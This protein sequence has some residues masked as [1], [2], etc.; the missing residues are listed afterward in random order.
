MDVKCACCGERR[1]FPE[2]LK[3]ASFPVACSANGVYQFL[4]GL[5]CVRCC[6]VIKNRAKAF[7]KK[8]ALTRTPL[9][10]CLNNMHPD[11]AL[12]LDCL[13]DLPPLRPVEE[14]LVCRVRTLISIHFLSGGMYSAKGHTMSFL[15]DFLLRDVAINLPRLAIEV[16][17]LLIAS[18]NKNT[19]Q[20][21]YLWVRRA[22]VER[23]LR[24]LLTQPHYAG[25]LIDQ[26]ALSALPLDGP[27][28]ELDTF[29][30]DVD[31][32]GDDAGPAPQVR[33]IFLSGVLHVVYH[34]AI[35]RFLG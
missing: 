26:A 18:K 21:R 4:S 15:K 23:W 7:Q 5:C 24:H 9:F 29:V 13:G 27:V 2:P 33:H 12:P 20:P 1:V 16:Q 11:P 8:T 35:C 32:L 28:L 10:G 6:L 17:F 3:L 31:A 19:D 14:A 25:V 22:V 34:V 30:A